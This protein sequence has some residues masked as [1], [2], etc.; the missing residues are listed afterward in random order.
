MDYKEKLHSTRDTQQI[1]KQ[2]KSLCKNKNLRKTKFSDEYSSINYLDKIMLND[3]FRSVYSE[4]ENFK[5]EDI[6]R[7]EVFLSNFII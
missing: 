5:I 2:L 1:C 6:T 7:N 3:V 4:E